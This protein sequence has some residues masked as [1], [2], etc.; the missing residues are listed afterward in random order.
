MFSRRLNSMKFSR[1]SSSVSILKC[2]NSVPIFRVLKMGTEL[3]FEK[4]EHFNILTLLL[5]RENF[6][7]SHIDV[8]DPERSS[9]CDACCCDLCSNTAYTILVIYKC[10]LLQTMY[11]DIQDKHGPPCLTLLSFCCDDTTAVGFKHKKR[12]F[13]R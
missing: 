12:L 3:V 4:S 13:F 1:A 2:T 8:S 11:H 6:I 5:A 9:R 7:E 10:S